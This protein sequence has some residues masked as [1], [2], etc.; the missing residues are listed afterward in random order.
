[1]Q[2]CSCRRLGST[3][4]WP[5][6]S[7]SSWSIRLQQARPKNATAQTHTTSPSSAEARAHITVALLNGI[8]SA[9]FGQ[10]N[11]LAGVANPLATRSYTTKP[12][13]SYLAL[14]SPQLYSAHSI[15]EELTAETD[16]IRI[17]IRL[18]ESKAEW[19]IERSTAWRVSDRS[20]G[21]R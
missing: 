20:R 15:Q 5:S 4:S 21:R 17:S 14:S 2:P 19:L 13:N 6:A 9:T 18:I 7:H 16:S 8:S 1:M 10:A 12:S 3:P 11:R